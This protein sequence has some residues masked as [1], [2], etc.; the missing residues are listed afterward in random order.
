MGLTGSLG[1]FRKNQKISALNFEPRGTALA[2]Q[3]MGAIMS[4]PPPKARISLLTWLQSLHLLRNQTILN[5]SCNLL[6]E[7]P[8]WK[9]LFIGTVP[10]N[11]KYLIRKVNGKQVHFIYNK[12]KIP[13]QKSCPMSETKN[14]AT[15]TSS[16]QTLQ[17]IQILINSSRFFYI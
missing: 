4:T 9:K 1:T 8:N 10:A 16:T 17:N 6:K 13:Q 2:L 3:Y 15:G 11:K 12:R 14:Y 7:F 5:I